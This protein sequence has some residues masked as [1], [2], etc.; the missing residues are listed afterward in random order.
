MASIGE[1][2]RRSGVHVET[3]RYYER[4][5]VVP[6]PART[7]AGR[8]DYSDADIRGLAFIR[9]CRDLGF[10]PADASRLAALTAEPRSACRDAQAVA[11]AHLDTLRARITELRAMEA[12]LSA[13]VAGCS[14]RRCPCP[15]RE[16]PEATGRTA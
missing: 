8:R 5:G 1:A 12:E 6:R 2:A 10:S 15:V 4:A 7:D 14:R 11:E 3:I 13:M 9:R 16:M